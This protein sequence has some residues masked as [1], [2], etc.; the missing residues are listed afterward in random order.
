MDRGISIIGYLPDVLKEVEEIK[1]LNYV[2][3]P[4]LEEEWRL[5]FQQLENQFVM[6]ADEY[7]ISRY[8]KML[9][10][11]YNPTEDIE[12]RRLRI[13]TR[14]KEQ[15]P[16]TFKVLDNILESLLGEGNYVL[17]R[18]VALKNIDVFVEL[19]VNSQVVII[20]EMLE[21]ILPANMIY[22][23]S[24]RFNKHSYVGQFKHLDLMNYTHKEIREYPLIEGSTTYNSLEPDTYDY[25]SS[26]TY[27]QIFRGDM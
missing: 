2:E 12:T 20:E 19:T 8:E 16:Y 26:Y 23:V 15:V 3:N 17:E 21:R 24:E 13:L 27:T 22:N 11:R 18:D 14:M 10:I 9:G 7:G 4:I 5:A 25:L 6:Y 1:A